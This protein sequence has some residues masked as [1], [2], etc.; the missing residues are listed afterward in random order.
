[1]KKKFLL[2]M[3]LF[4]LTLSSVGI[5]KDNA[6]TSFA[7]EKGKVTIEVTER[8]KKFIEGIEVYYDGKT[9]QYKPGEK[10][11]VGSKVVMRLGYVCHFKIY[12]SKGNKIDP[13]SGGGH[14]LSAA[15]DGGFTYQ[16]LKK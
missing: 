11:P 13:E 12:D 8:A 4:A 10:Y 6:K 16:I 14:G 1:M 9:L 2:N 5:V 7:E 3:I 15:V